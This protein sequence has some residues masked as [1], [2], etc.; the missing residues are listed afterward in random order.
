MMMAFYFKF[1]EY[2][3]LM[4]ILSI[5]LFHLFNYVNLHYLFNIFEIIFSC[6]L[7]NAFIWK[8]FQ[9]FLFNLKKTC[10]VKIL[11]LLVIILNVI[12]SSFF[13]QNLRIFIKPFLMN[14]HCF[15]LCYDISI[16]SGFLILQ[17]FISL[18]CSKL[19]HSLNIQIINQCFVLLFSINYQDQITN[20]YFIF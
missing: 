19:P 13:L 1:L 6:L 2:V 16:V 20:F 5:S 7:F 14:V 4:Q 10:T 17:S 11:R 8:T 3:L 12:L 9:I 18:E 15:A